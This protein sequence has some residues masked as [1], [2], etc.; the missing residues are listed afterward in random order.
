MSNFTRLNGMWWCTDCNS[1]VFAGI[2]NCENIE[3]KEE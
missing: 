1:E 2:C 3:D